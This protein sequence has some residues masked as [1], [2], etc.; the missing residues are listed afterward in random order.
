MKIRARK[1][2]IAAVAL[3]L[4]A[5]GGDDD[6]KD[7][8]GPSGKQD[9]GGIE[10]NATYDCAKEPLD[11]PDIGSSAA[12]QSAGCCFEGIAYLCVQGG[13]ASINCA[14]SAV[15]CGFRQDLNQVG[16]IW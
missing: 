15:S 10:A 3:G 2:A 6:T 9:A 8:P 11:C 1:I 13:V 5:C 16:C 12:V 7:N 4:L 14:G